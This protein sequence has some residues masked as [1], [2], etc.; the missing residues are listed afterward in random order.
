MLR[1]SDDICTRALVSTRPPSSLCK[2]SS[3]T[4][5]ASVRTRR[6]RSAASRLRTTGSRRSASWAT[7]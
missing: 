3:P 1:A 7:T 6:R 2:T 5:R 4:W